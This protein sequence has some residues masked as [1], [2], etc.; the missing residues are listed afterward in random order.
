[1]HNT[2][3]AF[4]HTW[5]SPPAQRFRTQSQRQRLTAGAFG[6]ISFVKSTDRPCRPRLGQ[7]SATF[8]LWIGA[9]VTR[10]TGQRH[11]KSL[12]HTPARAPMTCI[13]ITYHVCSSNLPRWFL[14]S[15]HIGRAS[16]CR[17]QVTCPVHRAQS[18]V[19]SKKPDP[20]ALFCASTATAWRASDMQRARPHPCPPRLTSTSGA[21]PDNL[22][23]SKFPGASA[24]DLRNLEN[25]G[26][27]L[28]HIPLLPACFVSG[29]E[30]FRSGTSL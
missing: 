11:C 12:L 30:I 26:L 20:L 17:S 4:A 14:I 3:R 5:P 18:R 21:G 15:T 19:S 29:A 27:G 25:H 22:H 2:T 16:D 24:A 8:Q 28:T 1:M 7:T 23:V 6:A 13:N 10:G 9:S